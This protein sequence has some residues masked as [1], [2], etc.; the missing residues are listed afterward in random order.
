MSYIDQSL[1]EGEVLVGRF[2]L[3]WSAWLPVVGLVAMALVMALAG[4]AHSAV[5]AL[6]AGGVLFVPAVIAWLKLLCLEM[7]VTNK[8][9]IHKT[10]VIGRK[11]DE[12]KLGSI[13]TVEINQGVVGRLLNYGKVR[14]TGKGVSAV[15]FRGVKDPMAVK[16]Q[17]ESVSNPAA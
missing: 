14:V 9:V 2:A 13:E 4:L 3:H 10:G 8:R 7:G 5:A 1:S 17:I 11:T 15:A 6:V 12:M 16:R